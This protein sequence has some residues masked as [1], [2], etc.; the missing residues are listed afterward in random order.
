MHI[1]ATPL[2]RVSAPKGHR[3]L[4]FL[5]QIRRDRLG[6][7]LRL[8]RE[9]GDFVQIDLGRIG[10]SRLFLLSHPTLIEEV[11]VI[12]NRSFRKDFTLRSLR[13]ELG[14]GLL[15]SEGDFWK[16]QRRLVQPA[17]HRERVAGYGGTMVQL[18]REI[19]DGWRDGEVLDIHHA[20]M[21]LA[22]RIVAKTLFD[23]ESRAE[24]AVIGRAVALSQRRFTRKTNTG[25]LIPDAWP[26][27][28]N[29]RFERAMRRLDAFIL[30]IIADRRAAPGD[31]GD[32]LSLLL[33]AQ[34]D[35][36]ARMT[37]QQLLDEVKTLFLAGHETTTNLMTWT[38]KLLAEHPDVAARLRAELDA[39][40][41]GRDP[42]PADLPT[43]PYTQ[44]VIAEA[45]RL[46]PP[47]WIVPREAIA[48]CT[49][50]GQPIEPGDGVFVSPWVVHRDGRFFA[51]PE[52]F[53][54][55]RWT[56]EFRR[57]LPAYAYFPFGGGQRKCVGEAFALMEA[58]L[59]LATIA[60]RV[61]WTLVPQPP[62]G[63]DPSVTL[64]PSR[65]VL[66]R[67][68]IAAG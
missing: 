40:L 25:F 3:I 60:R 53:L 68:A 30:G 36:G 56:P 16:R 47:A 51:E 55:E 43:L 44:Q 19:A 45:L 59:I 65:P 4:G 2:V 1:T 67:A 50:G 15:L 63:L 21:E 37:D 23:V 11:L 39:T 22:L 34:D 58:H 14:N 6:L 26:T 42:Q 27:P 61:S 17:F 20:M 7:F 54:P 8:A 29:V 41:A 49:I 9:H 28:T 52:R 32:L 35:D 64:R 57:Q 66:L 62:I 46:Y 18:T 38:W 5:R 24:N 48:P 10:R 13:R 31:R 12:G 33:G